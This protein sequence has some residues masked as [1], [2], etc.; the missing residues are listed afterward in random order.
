MLQARGW[1]ISSHRGVPR[2]SLWL[3]RVRAKSGERKLKNCPGAG[4][5]R[6]PYPAA[7]GLDDRAAYRQAHAHAIRLRREEGV[8]QPTG[9][10][11]GAADSGITD[12]NQYMFGV[13]GPRSDQKFAG[14]IV[15]ESHGLNA[16]DE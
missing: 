10:L 9:V 8:E 16:V 14:S 5:G 3:H 12:L 13:V 11:R 1:E 15:D 2:C 7:M 4:I 6:C